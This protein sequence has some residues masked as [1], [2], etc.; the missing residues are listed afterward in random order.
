MPTSRQGA[1]ELLIPATSPQPWYVIEGQ[2]SLFHPTYAGVSLGL[3]HGSQPDVFIVGR[4]PGRRHKLGYPDV[5]LPR[6]D[7]VIDVTS[8]LT[9]VT[10]P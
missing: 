6:I 4:E 5:P 7:E 10:I 9:G 3:L 1:A 8:G 2:G